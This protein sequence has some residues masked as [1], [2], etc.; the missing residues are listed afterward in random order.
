MPSH[1][2]SSPNHPASKLG[3]DSNSLKGF[4]LLSII[5]MNMI[6]LAG[7]LFFSWDIANVVILYWLENLVLGF[8]NIPRILL[9][10]KDG[11]NPDSLGAKVF[12]CC[13]FSV[14]YGIFCLVHG[15]FI[16]GI[17]GISSIGS[18]GLS[19]II[20]NPDVLVRGVI[21]GAIAIFITTG[22]NLYFDYIANKDYKNWTTSQA[23]FSPYGHIVIIHVAIIASAFLAIATGQPLWLLI[24]IIAGKT[25]LDTITRT[26]KSK[27]KVSRSR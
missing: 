16:V 8:W 2:K 15:V 9:A 3:S 6:P 20:S 10:G 22:T 23:M 24:L 25:A 17:L 11:K 12:S 26:K 4:T 13:F 21:Y 18:P 7:V 19:S 5:L 1:E 14:H 27:F